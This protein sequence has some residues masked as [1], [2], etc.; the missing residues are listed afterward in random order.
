[1]GGGDWGV[2]EE[3]MRVVYTA[4]ELS[5]VPQALVAPDATFIYVNR[6]AEELVGRTADELRGVS[7][8]AITDERSLVSGRSALIELTSGAV[9]TLRI[10]VWLT[11]RSGIPVEV[12]ITAAA[13][14]DDDGRLRY[15]TAAA[16]DVTDRRRTE[17]AVHHRA[18]H[19]SLTELPNR[20][21]FTERLGQALAHS[22]RHGSMIGVYFVDLDGFKDVNDEFGHDVGDQL[23]FV[24]AGRLDR[25]I[26]PG[27]TLARYGGDEF[28]ILCEDIPGVGEASEIAER[29]LRAVEAPVQVSGGEVRLSASI[30]VALGDPGEGTAASLIRNA[31]LA[32]YEA[33]RLGKGQYRVVRG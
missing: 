11:G 6:A 21:W 25:S 14:H 30:G 17:R 3:T 5:P 22:A 32:M 4:F 31:D 20:A 15:I 16:F 19:D 12:E 28:T 2:D 1:M 33:K 23:L 9:D 13:V 7:F 10:D 8:A 18:A 29:V 24:L 27:D 26:R